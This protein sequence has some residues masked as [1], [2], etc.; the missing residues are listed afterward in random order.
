MH[1]LAVEDRTD[2][3]GRQNHGYWSNNGGGAY[4]V[5][6]EGYT[7]TYTNT[8]DADYARA[9]MEF[10]NNTIETVTLDRRLQP[11]NR[12]VTNP[13]VVLNLDYSFERP[14]D[15]K[16]NG[17]VFSITDT[18]D[19]NRSQSF[20]YD[21]WDRLEGNVSAGYGRMDFEYDRW[22]NRT[23]QCGTGGAPTMYVTVSAGT[24]RVT[25]RRADSCTLTPNQVVGY[26]SGGNLTS[27]PGWT[28]QYDGEDRIKT[29]N[30]GGTAAYAYD[31]EGRR[32]KRVVGGQTRF[33]FY[34]A[35]GN[36][37][38]G[39]VPGVG[40]ETFNFFFQGRHL[41]TNNVT[42]GRAF[43]LGGYF[44]TAYHMVSHEPMTPIYSAADYAGYRMALMEAHAR[45]ARPEVRVGEI[46]YYPM[47][48]DE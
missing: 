11:V 43:G 31:G 44:G 24:N 40:Y 4:Q 41:A 6:V 22:E 46:R 5:L 32:V 23:K 45:T 38:W 20:V 17:N 26:D 1:A 42:N 36:P 37:L 34:D 13:A 10:G 15:A 8:S 9:V 3:E 21:F 27:E 14:G 7:L 25:A 39:Y 18:L 30:G 48:F 2:I 47:P 29:V 12:R 35:E 33:Y 19:L 16:N 28:Y